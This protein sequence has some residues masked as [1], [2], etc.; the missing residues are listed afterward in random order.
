MKK[1]IPR[2]LNTSQHPIERHQKSRIKWPQ[3]FQSTCLG[4][5]LYAVTSM[6]IAAVFTDSASFNAALS[7]SP[8]IETFDNVFSG[9]VIP[10]G[11]SFGDIRYQTNTGLDLV[12]SDHFST[13][14]PLNF[15]GSNDTFS[16][17]FVSGDEIF[18][19]FNKIIQAF[20][21]F[22]IGNPGDDIFQSDLQLVGGGL[23]VF[24]ASTPEKT[25]D[26]GG[27]VFFLGLINN[28]GFSNA[29]LNSFGDQQDPFFAFN[30]D[31]VTT[32]NVSEP[33]TAAL[34]SLGLVL[35]GF[36]N[37]QTTMNSQEIA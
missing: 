29:R 18:F 21:L 26:D 4:I 9:T 13:T 35:Y 7:Q 12:I 6:T 37:L 30:I 11:G 24:N 27:N 14:S 28:D 16:T 33:T 15:L 34:L 5:S 31:D 32:V 36:R 1:N 23:N 22:I 3:F 19:N 10:D 17:E 25:L 2:R 8:T 20:G